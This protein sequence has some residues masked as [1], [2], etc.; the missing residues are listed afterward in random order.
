[1][2][3]SPT[4]RRREPGK[5]HEAG[6]RHRSAAQQQR[7]RCFGHLDRR[8]EA[9]E[10]QCERARI[11]AASRDECCAELRTAACRI[12]RDRCFEGLRGAVEVFEHECVHP[13]AVLGERGAEPCIS[14]ASR[15]RSGRFDAHD[16]VGTHRLAA[17]VVTTDA[18]VPD[19]VVEEIVASEGF[20]NGW[21]VDL[22]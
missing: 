20:V 16:G 2:A 14:S 17:M 7:C 13:A 4:P 10:R 18:A 3:T 5:A 12:E 22:S 1:V 19:E 15:E 9:F 6:G 8:R 21:S 11:P